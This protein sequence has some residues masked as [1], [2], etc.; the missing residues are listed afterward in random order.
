M[1]KAIKKVKKKFKKPPKGTCKA[2]KYEDVT[3]PGS[4]YVNRVTNISKAEFEKNL[5]R[6][7]WKKSISKDGKTIILTKD[8]A[9][10]VLRDGAKSTGGSTADFYPK[11]SKRMTLKIRLK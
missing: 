8:G 9:K 6:D 1:S 10:Y 7:G 5:L 4:R 2:C 11:G 3:K